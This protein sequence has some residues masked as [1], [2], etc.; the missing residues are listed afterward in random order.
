M[1]KLEVLVTT[2]HQ[3]DLR[4]Y[5]EMNLQTD[6]VIANQ[7]DRDETVEVLIGNSRV[8]MVTTRTRG[9]SVNRNIAIQNIGSD[10]QWILFADDDL[11]FYD[12]YAKLVQETFDRHPE[13]DA[14]KYNLR[15]VSERKITMRPLVSFHRAKRWET[16]SWGVWGLAIKVGR[17]K[18]TRISF[19]ERFGPGTENYCGEDTIFFQELFKKGI[20]LY[21][22]PEYIADIDQSNSSWYEGYGE[23]YF[24]TNGMVLHE[25]YPILCIPLAV[26]SAW[27]FSRRENCH[28]KFWDILKCYRKG[29]LQNQKER[30]KN[31]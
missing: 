8:R 26:R 11:R 30:K 13:A 21:A 16:G 28:M 25:A 15:S 31:N 9:V 7:A 5:L 14:V 24:Q 22:S 3:P 17:L 1:S 20:N 23:R 12:G 6:A 4:K 29:I 18:E 10:S 19:H 2:M 27:R